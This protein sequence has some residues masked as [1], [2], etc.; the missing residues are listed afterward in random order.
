MIPFHVAIL[1][2]KS[3]HSRGLMGLELFPSSLRYPY[4]DAGRGEPGVPSEGSGKW[5]KMQTV[6]IT[7]RTVDRL[8]VEDRDA[9]FWDRDLPGFG[10]RV[11]P[12]GAKVFVVQCRGSGRSQ[13]VTLGRYGLMTV[14]A[15]RRKAALTIARIKNGEDPEGQAEPSTESAPGKTVAE[16]AERYMRE[17]VAIHCKA[18]SAKMYRR[19]L[20]TFILPAIGDVPVAEG[21]ARARGEAAPSV[22]GQTLPGESS[23]R[24]PEQD[25][26]SGGGLGMARREGETVPSCAQVHGEQA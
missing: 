10:V 22:E 6:S 9:V 17:H 11:Y 13:R 4:G 12:S 7:K 15:A 1:G 3:R 19:L 23:A 16:A 5:R 26:Q 8:S 24:N 20:D 21:H 18:T 2:L 25:I 14:E